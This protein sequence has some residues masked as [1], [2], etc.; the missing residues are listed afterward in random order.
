[1]NLIKFILMGKKMEEGMGFSV[2]TGYEA[3][4]NYPAYTN[5]KEKLILEDG[6]QV[7]GLYKI[8]VL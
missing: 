3:E 6:S 1:M 8:N 2:L 4:P 7:D 5:T